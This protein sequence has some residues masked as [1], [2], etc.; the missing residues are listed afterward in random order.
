MNNVKKYGLILFLREAPKQPFVAGFGLVGVIV[1]MSIVGIMS[2]VLSEMFK[3]QAIAQKN[4][5][6]KVARM[7]VTRNLNALQDDYCPAAPLRL[8]IVVPARCPDPTY[9]EIPGAPGQAVIVSQFDPT[10]PTNAQRMGGLYVRAK[11]QESP[12]GKK[13]KVEAVDVKRLQNI[14]DKAVWADVSPQADL[15]CDIN[16]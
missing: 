7:A 2:Y 6:L 12:S 8:R 13:L 15:L 14:P 4:L 16:R 1:A 11:C 9:V 3:N 10:N 5:D